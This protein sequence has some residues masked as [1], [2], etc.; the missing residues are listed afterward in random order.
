MLPYTDKASY[1]WIEG[2]A[3]EVG[4]T[5]VHLESL[6]FAWTHLDAFE[7]TWPHLAALGLT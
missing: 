3:Q 1:S 5:W 6:G 2:L 7:L 4:F